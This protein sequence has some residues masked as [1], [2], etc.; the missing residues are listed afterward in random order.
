MNSSTFNT[1]PWDD[2]ADGTFF[3]LT[4][5]LFPTAFTYG[6]SVLL[7]SYDPDDEGIAAPAPAQYDET[8]RPVTVEAEVVVSRPRGTQS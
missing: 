1:S 7:A 4:A 6:A 8:H 2:E 3:G 5:T